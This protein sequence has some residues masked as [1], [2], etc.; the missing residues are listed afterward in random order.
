MNGPKGLSPDTVEKDLRKHFI[1][2]GQLVDAQVMRDKACK[3]KSRGIAFVLFACS[4][5][6][7]AAMEHEEHILNNVKITL[8]FAVKDIPRYDNSGF[9]F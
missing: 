3:G 7:E 4:F 8:E 5:M 1:Q 9:G 2:F 6:A